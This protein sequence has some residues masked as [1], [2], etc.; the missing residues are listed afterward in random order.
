VGWEARGNGAYLRVKW[1]LETGT[2]DYD[3]MEN[4]NV[5]G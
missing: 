3:D 2:S 5:N 4:G 1:E